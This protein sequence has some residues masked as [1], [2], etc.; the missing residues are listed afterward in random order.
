MNV[1]ALF[2][3]FREQTEDLPAAILTLAAAISG[4]QPELLTVKQAAER[5]NVSPD[6]VYQ[7]V[8]AGKLRHQR[9]GK[10]RGTIRISAADLAP[11]VVPLADLIR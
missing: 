1:K 6:C 2:N 5:L 11:P 10:G 7:M 4:Q 3:Q 8:E 9:I